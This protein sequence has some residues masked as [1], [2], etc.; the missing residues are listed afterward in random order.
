MSSEVRDR[1]VEGTATTA[2]MVAPD[3]A[4]LDTLRFVGAMAV[5]TTHVTFYSGDYT[6]H[7]VLGTLLARL[8]VGV[9]VFFVL[10]GFLLSRP[11]LARA[12]LGL[13]RPSTG[14]YLLKRLLRIYPVYVVAVVAALTLLEENQDTDLREWVVTLLLANTFVD[15]HL[16]A[17]LSQM[18]SLGVEASFYL[19]LPLIVLAA[20]GVRRLRVWRVLLVLAAMSA[21]TV[22]WH[23]EAVARIAPEAVGS[24]QQWLP[25]YL[26]W[27][28]V[29]IAIATVHVEATRGRV[30]R[31]GRAMLQLGRQPGACWALAGALML[32]AA[33]P[34]AGPV[35]LAPVAAAESLTKN[36]LYAAV[37]GLLVLSGVFAEPGGRFARWFGAPLARHLGRTSYSV[38]CLHL[39][40]I[41]LI[42][43]KTDWQLFGGHG[44]Q[45][46]LLTVLTSLLAAEVTYRLVERPALRLKRFFPTRSGAALTSA[47]TTGTSIR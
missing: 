31:A 26:T 12:A 5:L 6:R 47:A 25:G 33:T 37:G 21:V 34:V 46:W 28:A 44:V 32:V 42:M 27:F 36:L 15:P 40:L 3:F 11:Y 23:L 9:A 22:W 7:G 16:P 18:W 39:L 17:G 41:D 35:L 24:P 8:D 2:E 19:V 1:A 29:G 43:A 38:F 30:G 45:L 13:P 14:H 10:S 20:T 4:V